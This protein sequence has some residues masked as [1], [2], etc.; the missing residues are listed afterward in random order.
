MERRIIFTIVKDKYFDWMV[1]PYEVSILKN[2]QFSAAS[3][4]ITLKN[5]TIEIDEATRK[6]LELC[7][8]MT[9]LHIAK[10]FH[11]N[12]LTFEEDLATINDK[13]F[14]IIRN[15][16]RDKTDKLL[17]ILEK[18][19]IP[20]Y[21]KGERDNVII[22]EEPI[23][24]SSKSLDI[25][26]IFDRS[27]DGIKYS[28]KANVGDNDIK[29]SKSD[30][31]IL[32]Y[33][34][35]WVIHKS[36]L[37]TTQ[38]GIDGKKI[39][40][41]LDKQQ[42]FIPKPHEKT[43]I[44]KFIKPLLEKQL[45]VKLNGDFIINEL[46]E[47]PKSELRL[48]LGMDMKPLLSLFFHYRNEEIPYGDKKEVFIFYEVQDAFINISK[49]KR[50]KEF[51]NEIVDYLNFIG[52]KHKFHNNFILI[53]LNEENNEIN[54]NE[55][56]YDYINFINLNSELFA[57]KN[58]ELDT[59]T[60]KEKYFLGKVE[61]KQH[62]K[63]SG[64]DWFDLQIEVCFDD[65]CIP[66]YVLRNN[67]LEN[68]RDFVLPDGR[69]AL[70]PREWFAQYKELAILSQKGKNNVKVTKTQ[71]KLFKE[72]N[73]PQSQ[74]DADVKQ[75]KLDQLPDVKIPPSVRKTLRPYQQKGVNWF[76]FLDQHDFGGILSDDMGLG[77]TI[78]VLAFLAYKK[79]EI[80]KLIPQST[81]KF[82]K[83]TLFKEKKLSVLIVMPLS[84][85]YNWINEIKTT[86]P[87]LS[88]FVYY[89]TNRK[90]NQ[91]IIS[92]YDLILT[93]YGTVRKDYEILSQFN[94]DYIFLDE[95][96]AIKNPS[97]K[98]FRVITKLNANRKFVLTGTPIENTIVDLWSQMSFVNPGL[99]GDLN[100]FRKKFMIPIEKDSHKATEKSLQQIISP[101]ILRRT[102][103]MVAKELPPLTER[104]YYCSMTEDQYSY[105]E[106]KKSEIRNYLMDL[107]QKVGFD[108]AYLSILSGITRLRLIANHPAII[109]KNYNSDSG[110]F[111]DVIENIQKIIVSDNKLVMFSQF[112]K[113]LNLFKDYLEA[114]DIPFLMLTGS[115]PMEERMKIV[116]EF[117]NNKD[118]KLILMSLK[119]GGV[120]I[121]L[122]AADFVFLLDPWWNPAVEYQAIN[123]THRIGQNKNV[124]SYK[125][126]VKDSIEE[127]ILLL[128]NK[129]LKFAQLIDTTKRIPI[130]EEDFGTL[131][132]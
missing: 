39:E 32:N 114:N 5:V 85:I 121:N 99:L 73:T 108:K 14:E 45:T 33:E 17:E 132:D 88:Y 25:I 40:P 110:K 31:F 59:K 43:Y 21:Y 64:I 13:T 4:P 47:I 97:S 9:Y 54:E 71:L 81:Q 100:S 84:L 28:L 94:F 58:I 70:L 24:F 22:N 122:T 62:I 111:N 61:L 102:K 92:K 26:F 49:V 67:I 107:K 34:P 131:F 3:K 89:G 104:T 105:Y 80:Q 72:I 10:V 55:T 66:F 120:G 127:K 128:Q 90:I 103:D 12:P 19:N 113:H 2:G 76:E 27:D 77:K 82:E 11:F 123:R 79:D 95:S 23:H 8:M 65:Y 60:F 119:A 35:C 63:K 6:A 50:N 129:K 38:P 7:S 16:L 56:L 93:T 96:Q 29:L 101:F 37:Y 118:I 86:A 112:V 117:Q 69:V 42:I 74:I 78:Q 41:F 98:I 1:V 20:L 109:D 44:E 130:T 91:N 36:I 83:N 46:Q 124:I 116:N 18:N 53:D 57:N 52:L 87:I 75:L 125:F 51:E 30:T 68:R 115:T 15:Y 48:E 106:E 126:I